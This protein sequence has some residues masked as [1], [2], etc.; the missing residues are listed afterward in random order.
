M[1]KLTT[2]PSIIKGLKIIG[3][4]Q[5]K[6]AKNIDMDPSY[7]GKLIHGKRSWNIEH[8][9]AVREEFARHG[10]TIDI[11]WFSRD[12]IKGDLNSNATSYILEGVLHDRNI[13]LTEPQRK[14]ALKMSKKI[15]THAINEVSEIIV[16]LA[17]C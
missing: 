13:T 9:K 6:F 7:F 17:E 12:D 2:A 10:V 1:K 11:D 5:Q 8:M 4:T 15:I 14:L 3:T 16:D